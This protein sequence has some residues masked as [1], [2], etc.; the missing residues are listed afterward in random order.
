MLPTFY[1]AI[2][3][4][5]GLLGTKHRAIYWQMLL[6]VFGGG[7]AFLLPA[8]G[9]ANVT[10]AV[11]FLP[12]IMFRAWMERERAGFGENTRLAKSSFWIL[13]VAT[14]GVLSAIMLPRVLSGLVE[15]MT[16]D[17]DSGESVT[18]LVPLRPVSGNI[19]QSG[20]AMGAAMAFMSMRVLLSRE[21]RMQHFKRA[22]LMIGTL[23]VLFA[24]LNLAEFYAGFPPVL[25]TLRNAGYVQ[26]NNDVS[27]GLVRIQGTFPETS[28][29]SM[30]TIP[31]FAFCLSLWLKD[32]SS[33]YAGVLAAALLSL[34]LLST[35]TTAYT[36]IAIY[37]AGVCAQLLWVAYAKGNLPRLEWIV[38]GVGTIVLVVGGAFVFELEVTKRVL[39]FFDLTV[40]SKLSSRSG[41]M[42][43]LWNAQAWAN[44]RDT[45]GLGV[46]MGSARASSFA[47]VLLSNLGALGTLMFLAFLREVWVGAR[48]ESPRDASIP[49]A[50]RHATFAALIAAC[51]SSTVF[52]LGVAFYAYAAAA[53]TAPRHQARRSRAYDRELLQ[54]A[55]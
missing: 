25:E 35:S 36:A 22:V 4:L 54:A 23:D 40:A 31:L 30:F 33:R 17:R 12:F 37:M 1:A 20:Y 26:F 16:V 39:E 42:R 24:L 27:G 11:A 53:T 3:V 29:F 48:L 8:L 51:M 7:A 47:L 41:D 46:G 28:M 50:A 14:W 49:S 55:A 9:G 43:A 10:P 45:Y 15:I 44:F 34:L 19:T 6:C 38:M 52:D 2:V 32:R 13:G 18:V 21:G 5:G